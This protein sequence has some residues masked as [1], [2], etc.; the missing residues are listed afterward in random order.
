LPVGPIHHS[1]TFVVVVSVSVLFLSAVV[2]AA[3]PA[4]VVVTV[5]SAETFV[6]ALGSVVAASMAFVVVSV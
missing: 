3:A 4:T 6:A 2:V 1:V 5:D